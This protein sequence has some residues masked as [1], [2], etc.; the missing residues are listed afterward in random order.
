VTDGE[1]K[2][3]VFEGPGRVALESF[4]V[5][6]PGPRQ[7]LVRATRTLV[8]AG[9]ELKAYVGDDVVRRSP[10]YP[11]YPG[12]SH[13]GVVERV[14]ADVGEV[15]VGDRVASQKTHA[16]HVLVDLDPP[17]AVGVE[18]DPRPGR[19]RGADWIQVLPEGV[20]DEQATFAVLGSVALHGVRK[21]GLRLDDTCAVAGQGVV[22][23][24]AAQLARLNG[25]RPVIALDPAPER[26][27]LSRQSG[28]DA[29]LDP[30][31]PDVED[32]VR[33]LT[34]GRGVDVALDCT[35]TSAGFPGLLRLA[36]VEGRLVIIGS[37]VGEARFSLFREVQLKEL[38]IVGAF[39]PLAPVLP[40]PALP[41]T[42]AANRRAV[43]EGIGAGRLRVDHLISHRAPAAEAGALYR[44][45]AGG[46]RS[47]LGV[48][49]EWG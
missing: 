1:G 42:Q 22:G 4:E 21:A 25:A 14:G 12:Y 6:H 15:A 16:S 44:L 27:A 10:P 48:V 49:F 18:A 8:S 38:S 36:A 20:T 19:R 17:P 23:Q 11:V 29:Q 7:V 34:A 5:P 31:R 26:L 13:V 39:Q 2:R 35:S 45:M 24:L 30:T 43:L 41:W 28:T 3:I 33:A 40:H 46:P 32:A 9:T 37:L 47:W